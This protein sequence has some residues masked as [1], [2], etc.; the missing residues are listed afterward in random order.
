MSLMQKPDRWDYKNSTEYQAALKQY[1]TYSRK[2]KMNAIVG[3]SFAAVVAL[4]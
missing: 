4:S 2:M 1:E 3:G